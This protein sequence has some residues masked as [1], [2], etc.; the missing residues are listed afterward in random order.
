MVLVWHQATKRTLC[1]AA[2][3]VLE[4]AV[5][6]EQ[7]RERELRVRSV[8]VRRRLIETPLAVSSQLCLTTR[9]DHSTGSGRWTTARICV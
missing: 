2:G 6:V 7:E 3:C 9:S 5:L 8:R 1:V 4:Y